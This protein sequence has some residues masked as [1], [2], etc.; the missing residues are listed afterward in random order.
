M[1]YAN[2]V[3]KYVS[4]TDIWFI[5]STTCHVYVRCY[6]MMRFVVFRIITHL[7]TMER[8]STRYTPVILNIEVRCVIC[9]KCRYTY[10][11]KVRVRC[12]RLAWLKAHNMYRMWSYMCIHTV[13][14]VLTYSMA[15]TLL[16][17]T[18]GSTLH[19]PCGRYLHLFAFVF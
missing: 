13:Q 19:I 1:L 9:L 7:I 15:C 8:C 12:K 16:V 6:Y 18:L 3:I 11:G 5:S 14:H 17:Y 10:P 4:Y 2:T